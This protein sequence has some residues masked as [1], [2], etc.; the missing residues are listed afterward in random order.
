MR[1]PLRPGDDPDTK[2]RILE[3][4][5]TVFSRKGYH[6]TRVDDIALESGTS[7]GGFYFH[8]ASKEKIFLALVDGFADLLEARLVERISA[9]GGGMERLDA[10]LAVCVE[11]FGRYKS[12][13]KIVLVQA[14]GLGFSFEKKRRA[15]ENRFIRIIRENIEEAA[16]SGSIPPLDAEIAAQIW[17]GALN[18]IV[19]RWIESGKPDPVKSLP[20]IRALLLRSIG[21]APEKIEGTN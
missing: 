4:A 21:V 7:K 14:A 11:T 10:A 6:E 20:A 15:V 1:A 2:K 12:L 17:M 13:A 9:A 18:G 3:A 16:A 5:A 19:M 8:W